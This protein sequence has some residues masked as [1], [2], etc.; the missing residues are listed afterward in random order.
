ME[1]YIDFDETVRLSNL[2]TYDKNNLILIILMLSSEER[3]KTQLANMLEL[4]NIKISYYL[5]YLI[6]NDIVVERSCDDNLITIEKLYRL[7]SKEILATMDAHSE[8]GRKV[9]AKKLSLFL[10]DSILG[11]DSSDENHI[12]LAEISL[13][14]ESILKVKAKLEE[15]Y[16][17]IVTLEKDSIISELQGSEMVKRYALLSSFVPKK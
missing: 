12:A 13:N 2:S 8:L 6:T 7:K 17:L 4:Q 10:E 15:L 3:S 9:Q 11:V 5:D 16:Q 14:N 1:G